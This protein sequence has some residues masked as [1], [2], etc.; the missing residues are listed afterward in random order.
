MANDKTYNYQPMD[1]FYDIESVE[2]AWTFS[3]YSPLNNI[4]NVFIL[5]GSDKLE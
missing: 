3:H 1:G 4:V 5:W 2:D